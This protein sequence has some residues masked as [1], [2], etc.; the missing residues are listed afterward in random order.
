MNEVNRIL[1]EE[2]LAIDP[3]CAHLIAS[4]EETVWNEDATGIDKSGG[5]EHISDALGYL[6]CELYPLRRPTRVEQHRL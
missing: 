3:A 1:R 6:V 5:V 2:K 4:L